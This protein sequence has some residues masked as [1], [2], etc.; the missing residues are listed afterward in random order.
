[1]APD[2]LVEHDLGV[3][4]AAQASV[5]PPV[6]RAL[7]DLDAMA[8]GLTLPEPRTAAVTPGHQLSTDQRSKLADKGKAMPDG[9]FPIRNRGDL[10]NAIQSLGR[11][12]DAAAARKWIIRRARE[13]D[14]VDA[15]PDDWNIKP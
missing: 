15:L 13:L 6:P 11:A 8:A 1:M 3:L 9:A 5:A 14:A 10:A 2:P 4:D 12:K 7:T